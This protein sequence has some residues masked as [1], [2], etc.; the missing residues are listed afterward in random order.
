MANRKKKILT[1]ADIAKMRDIETY[2]HSDKKRTNNPPVGMAQHDKTSE[3][4]KTYQ[5]DPHLDPTLQW[6]G[7]A[8]GT[9]FEIPTSSIH[10]HE[11]IKPHKIIRAVQSIGD[12]YE[13][14][15]G[16]S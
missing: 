1:D 3:V 8:E 2:E 11:S 13:D 16:F 14:Q 9:S 6:A 12:D 7:K 15:Q 10:I 5:F 4:I